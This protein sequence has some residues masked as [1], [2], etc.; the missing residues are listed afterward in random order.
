MRK[1]NLLMLA[2]L[3]GFAMIS[4]QACFAGP[5]NPYYNGGYGYYG[6]NGY[7]NNGWGYG[8]YRSDDGNWGGGWDRGWGGGW[9][10]EG[11]GGGDDDDD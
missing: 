4:M 10:G 11:F 3:A 5:S 1:I 9:G 7:G 6:G 8:G 2:A